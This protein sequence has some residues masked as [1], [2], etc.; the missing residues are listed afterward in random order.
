MEADP[1]PA[2][3]HADASVSASVKVD[4]RASSDRLRRRYVLALGSVA[5]LSIVG[6]ALLQL[7]FL[8]HQG[9]ENVINVASRQRA[10]GERLCKSALLLESASHFDE[11]ALALQD[12]SQTAA[13]WGEGHGILEAELREADDA[14]AEQ[15]VMFAAIAP[16]AAAMRSAVLRLV[17][18]VDYP[19]FG[20]LDVASRK[21]I[22]ELLIH[23]NAFFNGMDGIVRRYEEQASAHVAFLQRAELTVLAATLFALIMAGVLVFRPAVSRVQRALARQAE[24]QRRAE[25]IAEELRT[26]NQDLDAALESAHRA[27]RAK[28]EF[29]ANMSHEIRTPLNGVIGMAELMLTTELDAEQRDYV[30][31]MRGAGQSLATII[32]DILDFS[33]IEARCLELEELDVD[34]RSVVDDVVGLMAEGAGSKGVEIISHVDEFI[35]SSVAGD[36][37]RIRQVL[38]NLVGNAVK[39]TDEGEVLVSAVATDDEEESVSVRFDV[40]DTGIGIAAEDHSSLFDSFS[41][42]DGSTTR[43]YG[44][45]GLG[46]AISHQLAGLMG[47]TITVE[48]ALAQGSTFTFTVRLRKHGRPLSIQRPPGFLS[49]MRVL[50]VDDNTS[51]CAVLRHHLE[52]WGVVVD[53]SPDADMAT[54]ILDAG[55]EQGDPVQAVFVD[56][57]LPDGGTDELL[58]SLRDDPAL[59]TMPV[60]LMS[61]LGDPPVKRQLGTSRAMRPLTKPVRRERLLELLVGLAESRQSDGATSPSAAGRELQPQ[62][63]ESALAGGPP[64]S[65]HAADGDRALMI[66]GDPSSREASIVA[67]EALGLAVTVCESGVAAVRLATRAD[68]V[69]IVADPRPGD[70]APMDVSEEIQRRRPDDQSPLVIPVSDARGGDPDGFTTGPSVADTLVKPIQSEALAVVLARRLEVPNTRRSS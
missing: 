29:L 44:G 45:T 17:Q 27:T 38:L 25:G 51:L 16:R 60:V 49:G 61:R 20:K 24:E 15:Q 12:L 3:G 14:H 39:F 46:L 56:R 22:R 69:V 35:P 48:S 37:G 21:A 26:R 6:Q 36:A 50:I 54:R 2:E 70:M 8:R 9:S 13:A 66:V 64:S 57:H 65:W 4:W 33:K 58:R 11:F 68:F 5:L 47:G 23:D 28:S 63:A 18:T 34:V 41:Q 42:V 43:R 7:T 55:F 52:A 10:L 32:N 62:G 67:V 19:D 1:Q 40:A 59:A 53:A 30:Q 31:T